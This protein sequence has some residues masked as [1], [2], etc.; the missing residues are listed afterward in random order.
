MLTHPRLVTI[1][2]TKR[3][4]SLPAFCMFNPMYQASVADTSVAVRMAWL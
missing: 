1:S 3:P 4:G 2:N